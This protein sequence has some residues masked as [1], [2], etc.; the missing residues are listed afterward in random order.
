MEQTNFDKLMDFVFK[1]EG[2]LCDDPKDSGGITKYGIILADL[3]EELNEAFEKE[4]AKETDAFKKKQM[5]CPKAT[6]EDIINLTKEHA[7]KIY[8][9]KYWLKAK[10]DKILNDDLALAYCDTCINCGIRQATFFL[11]RAV[12]NVANADIEVD[13]KI[14]DIT[15]GAVNSHDG[16]GI[17]ENFLLQRI[18]FY[19][20]LAEKKPGQK[21]FLRGW[22]N[23][24]YAL[25][26][27][28][29]VPINAS[30]A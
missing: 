29:D 23:R 8:Y 27:V 21:V 9:E 4:K 26:N 17:L 3:Q 1:W 11:Q 25:A 6:R 20:T 10:C 14:G 15:I 13:G 28:V 12:N 16:S 18:T 24:S 30:V 19:K 22:L 7:K 5:V 2:G